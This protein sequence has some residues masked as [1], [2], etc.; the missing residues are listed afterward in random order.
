MNKKKESRVKLYFSKMKNM[1]TP[2][3][4]ITNMKWQC[5]E[6]KEVFEPSQELRE[7]QQKKETTQKMP[8]RGT[9]KANKCECR[10]I[11]LV[12]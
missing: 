3:D 7:N 9:Q 4:S 12:S 11:K 8:Q 5:A 1:C 2:K 10:Y 6:W